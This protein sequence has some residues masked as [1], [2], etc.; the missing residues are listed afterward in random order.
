V[1][2]Q[3]TAKMGMVGGTVGGELELNC[4]AGKLG[5]KAMYGFGTSGSTPRSPVKGA[6]VSYGM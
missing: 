5:A 3:A 1:F 6:T 2:A 4:M